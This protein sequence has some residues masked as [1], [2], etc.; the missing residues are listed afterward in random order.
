MAII[1][2]IFRGLKKLGP[3][4]S[5][6]GAPSL[7]VLLTA[8]ASCKHKILVLSKVA[9]SF[10]G[11]NL[12]L[13]TSTNGGVSH[14]AGA[15]NYSWA[16]SAVNVVPAT[17]DTGAAS[18]TAIVIAGGVGNAAGESVNCIITLF[19][20]TDVTKNTRV[21]Y[22]G[23]SFNVNAQLGSFRGGGQRNAAQDTDSVQ[24]KFNTGTI[25]L[26]WALYGLE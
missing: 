24:I 7:D 15:G 19:D 1:S 10:D 17:A 12:L 6:A 4:G 11:D 13:R 22:E 23:V 26:D 21:V 9:P 2:P 8:Y 5:V 25:T 16:S 3:G 18:D 14:D 20:T